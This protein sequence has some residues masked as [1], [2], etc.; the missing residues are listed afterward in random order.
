MHRIYHIQI[1]THALGDYFSQRALRTILEANQGQD[2][3]L[4]QIGHPEYH[5]DDNLIKA[6]QAY[7]GK[8]RQQVINS[9]A[10]GDPPAAWRAFGRLTHAAQDFYAHSNYVRLWFAAQGADDQQAPPIEAIE[11]LDPQ[12]L[13]SPD[14]VSGR[15]YLLELLTFLPG[16]EKPASRLLRRDAHYW[17]NLDTPDKGPLFT[18]AIAAARKRTLHEFEVLQTLVEP[19]A[20]QKFIDNV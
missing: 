11:A 20:W 16:L 9:L 4:G 12:I 3:L 15:V 18:Y 13:D 5:F 2:R 19:I 1:T 7:M 10:E 14:L 17:M 6:G 8:E